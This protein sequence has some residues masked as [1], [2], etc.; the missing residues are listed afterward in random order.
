[1][2]RPGAACCSRAPSASAPATS[3]ARSR[4]APATSSR[5]SRAASTRMTAQLRESYAD[6]EKKVEDRTAELREALDQQTATADVLKV[7]SGSPTD[8]MPVFEAIVKSARALG[9]A[10]ARVRVP[11]R[12]R[13]PALR[14]RHRYVARVARVHRRRT[15]PWMPGPLDDDRTRDPRARRSSRSTDMRTRSRLRPDEP[16]CAAV[17]GGRC[18]AFR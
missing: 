6:L 15:S 11:V 13:A 2:V 16:D 10:Q 17:R 12:R 3:T 8:V 4:C 7:I 9:D 5:T 1:M 18:W 14:D